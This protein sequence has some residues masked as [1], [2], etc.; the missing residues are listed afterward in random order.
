LI[1]FF[2]DGRITEI[3]T[4]LEEQRCDAMACIALGYIMANSR[5]IVRVR[6]R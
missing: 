5:G 6:V 4:R 1:F 3:E 2:T